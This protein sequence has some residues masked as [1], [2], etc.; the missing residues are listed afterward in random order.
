VIRGSLNKPVTGYPLR[1]TVDGWKNLPAP[2]S[3][4]DT[5]LAEARAG[6]EISPRARIRGIY[7]SN[8][9]LITEDDQEITSARGDARP[10]MHLGGDKSNLPLDTAVVAKRGAE[11][12]RLGL[13]ADP[14]QSTFAYTASDYGQISRFGTTSGYLAVLVL[15]LYIASPETRNIYAHPH[16]LWLALPPIIYWISRVWL[17]TDRGELSGDPVLFALLDRASYA[18]LACILVVGYI[19]I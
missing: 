6:W 14:G 18:A 16:R 7:D 3:N 4:L 10:S 15:A 5:S 12:R 11:L 19:A 8:I 17:L 1:T 2:S 13:S 9:F